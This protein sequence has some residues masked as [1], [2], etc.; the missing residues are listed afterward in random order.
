MGDA[1]GLATVG[2]PE[3]VIAETFQN[4]ASEMSQGQVVLDDEQGFGPAGQ[5]PKGDWRGGVLYRLLD[6]RKI[7]FDPYFPDKDGSRV[8]LLYNRKRVW[9][10]RI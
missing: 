1:Q 9:Q 7:D 6:T 8:K 2:R 4:F 10:R 5:R 3:H